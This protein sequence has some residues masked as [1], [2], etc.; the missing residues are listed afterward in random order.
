MRG[1]GVIL[2]AAGVCLLARGQ[3]KTNGVI[4]AA[5]LPKGTVFLT[6]DDGPDEPGPD[7]VTQME[8]VARYLHGPVSIPRAGPANPKPLERSIRATF[9]TVTCHYQHQ[10]MGDLNSAL[11][12]GYG[13][14]PLSAATGVV[15]LGHDLI[16]HSVNHIPLTTIQDPS[17]ILYEVGHAQR[18]LDTLQGNSPR[19]FRGPGLAFNGQVAGVLNADA[20]AGTLI[21]PIDANV[22]GD[23]YM[24]GNRWMG[25]DWDCVA[26]GFA[27]A[28]CGALY[29]DAIRE[30]THGVIVLLH[31]RT[32]DLSGRDGNPYPI[33]LIHYIVEH[34]GPDYEYLPLDAIPGVLGT[35][36][37]APARVST[38]F[39]A[40]DGQGQVVEGGILGKGNPHGLCK[41]R[42]QTVFC[43]IG[44]GAGG[45]RPSTA[46]LTVQDSTWVSNYG[47]KFWLADVNGDGRAD[48][49][50]PASGT[51]WVGYNNGGS[52]FY[53]PIQYLSGALP[54]PRYVH[55]GKIRP[56][57]SV[58]M[59]VWTPDQTQPL[60]YVNQGVRFAAPARGS[61]A[62]PD[63]DNARFAS[64]LQVL[65]LMDVNGDG[66]EDLVI[67]GGSSVQ[68]AV[69]N[70]I[71]FGPLQACSTEG[72]QFTGAQG[73]AKREYSETFGVANIRGPAVVGGLATGLIFAPVM[74]DKMDPVVSD[75]YRYIC[76]D[77]F[78][79]SADPSWRPDLR[80]SQILW[81][82]FEGRGVDSPCLV[83]NDGLY[84]GL[85]QGV[86]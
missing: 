46:W 69:S 61:H 24:G 39:G 49:I 21:G 54:E 34:L 26:R 16:N 42:N 31:V 41:A 4:N 57:N 79:N 63:L 29:V 13:N 38:E 17:K 35:V 33:N 11:C 18:L 86:K 78:T 1:A 59:V 23:F 82:D 20:Y 9:A 37:A 43:K 44:D 10:D 58:D 55:F 73:W 28:T 74:V 67:P 47:S 56:G 66:L 80:A 75:R 72:G 27:V 68:C 8:K 22:G 53:A 62:V 70:G 7:G 40:T 83:R 51:L 14:V 71:G 25:G 64:E 32:E 52:G 76:N 2:A 5:A 3:F 15:E 48:L 45:F 12:R 36:T 84:L 81:G 60:V 19:L 65:Q 6:F 50:F 85:T 30:A 77:C